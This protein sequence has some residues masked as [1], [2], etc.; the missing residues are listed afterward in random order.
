[1]IGI[2][3]KT[4]MA[5]SKITNMYWIRIVGLHLSSIIFNL[6]SLFMQ[7][8]FVWTILT[9]CDLNVFTICNGLMQPSCRAWFTILSR[10]INVPV[11]PTPALNKIVI[12]DLPESQKY[13]SG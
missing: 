9:R 10:P 4:N 3:L 1:V 8:T 6:L 13:L 7:Y 2:Q 12:N 11:L 5:Y